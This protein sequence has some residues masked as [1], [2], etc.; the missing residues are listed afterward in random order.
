MSLIVAVIEFVIHCPD[1]EISKKELRPKFFICPEVNLVSSTPTHLHSIAP[2]KPSFRRGFS[3]KPNS[4][5]CP[6]DVKPSSFPS[7]SK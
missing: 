7:V 6:A 3:K 5:L 2:N 4:T 1:I